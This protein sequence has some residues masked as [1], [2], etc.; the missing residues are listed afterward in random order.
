MATIAE[1]LTSDNGLITYLDNA[2]E[3]VGIYRR[4]Q[5]RPWNFDS[6]STTQSTGFRLR[7]FKSDNTSNQAMMTR[8]VAL[9]R[10]FEMTSNINA[11]LEAGAYLEELCKLLHKA[12]EC[13][14]HISEIDQV[15]GSTF[16]KQN[17]SNHKWYMVIFVQFDLTY[18]YS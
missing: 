3:I 13:V 4:L 14:V 11:T 9:G 2:P 6:A 8:T 1:I 12:A 16:A 18:W 7:D 10:V 5:V 17:T 15:S